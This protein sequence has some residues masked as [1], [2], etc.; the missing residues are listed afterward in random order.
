MVL[1]REQRILVLKHYFRNESYA[2]CQE[3]FQ[4]TF[5]NDTVPSKTAIYRIITEFEETGSVCEIEN[6]TAVAPS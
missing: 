6:I 1:N 3:A 2:L 5:P 4:E